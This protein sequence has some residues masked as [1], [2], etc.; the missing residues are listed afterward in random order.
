[1]KKKF[2][3]PVCRK[4]LEGL[5]IRGHA[6]MHFPKEPEPVHQGQA[7]AQYYALLEM[8]RKEKGVE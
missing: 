8:D 6:L 3:C 5:D 4:D 1:M 7:Y 2:V